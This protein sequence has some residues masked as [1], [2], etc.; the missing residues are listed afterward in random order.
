MLQNLLAT[1]MA[2]LS[3][4]IVFQTGNF[5]LPSQLAS[6]RDLDFVANLHMRFGGFIKGAGIVQYS[7]RL[8]RPLRALAGQSENA[9]ASHLKFNIRGHSCV[10]RGAV[11]GFD[12]EQH[13]NECGAW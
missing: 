2:Q 1:R 7:L 4:T 12:S 5:A 11:F 10:C 6:S 9:R 8:R 3:P 13:I